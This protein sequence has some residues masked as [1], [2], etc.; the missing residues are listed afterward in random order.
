MNRSRVIY[1]AKAVTLL[2]AIPVLV[3]AFSS[4][5]PPARTGA[6]GEGNCTGCHSTNPAI[7]NSE[8]I[9]IEFPP[10]GAVYAPGEVQQWTV[11]V[12][13]TSAV[14]YGFQLSTRDSSNG[15]AGTLA[16]VNSSTQIVTQ[17]GIQYIEQT[18]PRPDGS[19]TIQWTAPASDI[20]E[21]TV[22]VAANAANW[23]GANSGYRIHLRQFKLTVATPS[24]PKP[25]LSE[26]TPVVNG[27]SFLPGITQGSWVS[28]FGTELAPTT[29]IWTAEEIIDGKLPLELDG[30]RVNI[31]GKA[32]AVHYI[33]PTQVNVQ[34]PDDTAEGPVQVEVIRDGVKSDPA[35]ANLQ[36]TAP[37]F[38]KFSQGGNKYAAAVFGLPED[39]Q[40]VYVGPP[41]LFGGSPRARPAKENDILLLYGTGFGPT[42]PAVPSGQVFVGAAPLVDSI[43]IRIGG[44]VAVWEFAGLSGAGL[45]QFNV[46]VPAGLPDGDAA[47]VA[48]INGLQTQ[49]N[50][51]ILIDN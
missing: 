15:Q 29:R 47:V 39:G 9:Q 22:Y 24:K 4:G 8:A 35:V 26:G 20:G 12:S 21:I 48:E 10:A 25:V 19:F 30:V 51:F 42:D 31:N 3:Y 34:A 2:A 33:S 41:D 36:R 37:G 1:G 23:N 46:R 6:P 16:T 7:S 27:A 18:A 14:F 17:S 32:G 40:V 13:D 44:V 11:R 43:T 5:P 50:V 45:N 38:F 28:V 49:E